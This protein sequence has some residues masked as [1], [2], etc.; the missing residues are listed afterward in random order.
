MQGYDVVL[1][2]EA[3]EVIAAMKG[4]SHPDLVLLSYKLPGLTGQQVSRYQFGIEVVFSIKL[5]H[6]PP[7]CAFAACSSGQ[8]KSPRCP[9]L[10]TLSAS[11]E[12]K[13]G[14]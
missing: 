13:R 6:R 11:G 4:T 3:S 8:T 10:C 12:H 9:Y 7:M 1:V 5:A 14:H 2:H